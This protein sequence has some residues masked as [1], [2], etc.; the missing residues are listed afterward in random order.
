MGNSVVFFFFS[1]FFEREK[2]SS[3]L[4]KKY[5]CLNDSTQQKI[6]KKKVVEA[7]ILVGVGILTR[8]SHSASI[9]SKHFNI[10]R[11]IKCSAMRFFDGIMTCYFDIGSCSKRKEV[12]WVLFKSSNETIWKVQRKK[13]QKCAFFF[14]A[15][16]FRRSC[17]TSPFWCDWLFWWKKK[18]PRK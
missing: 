18:W 7:F 12:K 9:I 2:E 5:E 6:E 17:N 3:K 16:K 14:F 13:S 15:L 1:F 11:N 4:D 8:K 10:P